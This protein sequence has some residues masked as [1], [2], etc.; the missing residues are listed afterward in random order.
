MFLIIYQFLKIPKNKVLEK[1]QKTFIKFLRL[2]WG[3][4]APGTTQG[5]PPCHHT[6]WWRGPS[7]A[8][9][10]HGVV[11]SPWPSTYSSTCHSTLYLLKKHR[12]ISQTCVLTVLAR[13]F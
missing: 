5:D 13:V 9:P 4:E 7:L 10:W 12:T 1:F 2:K 8:A 3:R 11:W 6:T